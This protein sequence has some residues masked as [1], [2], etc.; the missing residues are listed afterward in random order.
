MYCRIQ[1][2]GTVIMKLSYRTRLFMI[3]FISA[4]IL[5]T[6]ISISDYYRFKKQIEANS[7]D[8]IEQATETVLFALNSI[9]R[10]YHYMDQEIGLE[11]EEQSK[12]LQKKYKK[13]KNFSKWDFD[14][15]SKEIGMDVYI[16]DNE[17]EVVYSN[18][19]EDVGIEFDVCCIT[20]NDILHERRKTGGI[21]IDGIDREQETGDAKKYSYATTPDKKYLIELG[22][23][24]KNELLFQN[25]NFT[26]VTENVIKEFPVIDDVTV[27]NYGGKPYGEVE[28]EDKP[29]VRRDAFE[30]V[31]ETKEVE[32]VEQKIQGITYTYRYIPYES[33]NDISSTQ[34]KVVEVM[35]NNEKLYGEIQENF[36]TM[37]IQFIIYLLIVAVVAYVLARLL[38]KPLQLAYYD[39]LT[40]LKNRASFEKDMAKFQK[41]EQSNLGLFLV[42]IDRFKSINVSLGRE[43]SNKLLQAIAKSLNDF[44]KDR[45]GEVYTFGSDTFVVVMKNTDERDA[46]YVAPALIGQ[47]D[48]DVKERAIFKDLEIYISIGVALATDESQLVNVFEHAELALIKAK[49][50][51]HHEFHIYQ[52]DD[53]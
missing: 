51:E 17:N 52:K 31:R 16:L 9:D 7:E 42:D 33:E 3:L 13:N 11:M 32:E 25:F 27:L 45:E 34:T 29:K 40:N 37:V 35:Y 39:R 53:N 4:L 23:S 20:L 24:L 6:T 44:M 8:Q 48:S 41:K 47:L 14:E 10:A 19:E 12:A 18:V 38:A 49:Q 46:E 36:K 21:F 50:N 15:I 2:L 43:N 28:P 1:N 5:L 22:F 30:S 26:S